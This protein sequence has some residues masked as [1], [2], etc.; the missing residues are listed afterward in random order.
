MSRIYLTFS[1]LD[2]THMIS[3]HSTGMVFHMLQR[4][5]LSPTFQWHRHVTWPAGARGWGMG[6]GGRRRETRAFTLPAPVS[7]CVL[8]TTSDK[9][10][11]DVKDVNMT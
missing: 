6:E 8:H 4:G 10:T 1:I 9:S 3:P 2:K 5:D 7:S 11:T